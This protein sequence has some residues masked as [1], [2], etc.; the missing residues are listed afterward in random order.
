MNKYVKM[1][2]WVIGIL[3]VGFIL[4]KLFAVI[5]LLIILAVFGVGG[6]LMLLL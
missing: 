5:I 2:L 6:T 4:Y 3:L 1:L